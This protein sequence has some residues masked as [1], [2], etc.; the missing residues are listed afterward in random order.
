MVDFKH[1]GNV[2]QYGKNVIDFSA[3]INPLGLPEEVRKTISISCDRILHYPDCKAKGLKQKIAEYWGINE[4]NVL[5]G[6]GS[7][8][9]IYLIIHSFV[10]KT[11][12]IFIPTFSEYERAARCIKSQIKFIELKDFRLQD[13]VGKADILF[14]C[15]P[16]NP[17]GNFILNKEQSEKL[18]SKLIVVDEAFMDFL[19][20]EPNHTLIWKACESKNLLV[21]RTFTKFFALAGLRIGY[22]VAHKDIIQ[23]LMQY[24]IPWS[25]N[26][27]AQEAA[28]VILDNKNYIDRTRLFIEEERKFLFDEIAGIGGLIPYPSVVN[29]LLV[30]IE[31]KNVTSTI[32]TEK[33]I[34]AGILIRDCSNFRG[35]TDKYIRVAIRSHKENLMLIEKLKK[36]VK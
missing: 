35:L 11:T 25:V 14:L 17:T 3:N 22:L 13:E 23:T 34:E 26:A 1:G 24:Q 21:L 4:E 2:Y 9:L 32:L 7:V 20:D 18:V 28:R 16:N 19:S 10:P 29:F 36:G 8:E 5:V 30:R 6:N 31:N 12:A 15:N 33:F 27:L